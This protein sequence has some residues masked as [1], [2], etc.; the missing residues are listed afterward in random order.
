MNEF[1]GLDLGSRFVKLAIEKENSYQFLGPYDTAE[2]YRRCIKSGEQGPILRR[3]ILGLEEEQPLACTGYGRVRL[4][5]GALMVPELEAIAGG[6]S[7][8]AGIRDGVILDIGGQDSKVLLLRDGRIAGF[9]AN[10]RCAASSGRFLENMAR[11]LGIELEDIGKY[12]EDPVEMSS[13]CAIFGETE[14][15][16]LIGEG[17]STERLAAGVNLAVLRRLMPL[18]SRFDFDT[19]IVTGGVAY[20]KGLQELLRKKTGANII[21]PERPDFVA[22]VGCCRMIREKESET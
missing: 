1:Y 20:N 22:S 6:V 16:G 4:E 11:A 14:L 13:T 17:Y 15:V 2:F 21:V 5:N 12:W 3:D 9:E 19:L 18:L 10:D 8:L 7:A